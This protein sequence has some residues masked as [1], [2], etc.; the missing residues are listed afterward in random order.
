MSQTT[1]VNTNTQLYTNSDTSKT[2]IGNNRYATGTFNNP[3]YDD[4]D[5]AEG[6]VLGRAHATGYV[7][8]CKSD[9][10]DGS[11][12][13]IGVL[14][15]NVTAPEGDDLELTYCIGGDVA[16]E[17]LVFAKSGDDLD[18][19]VSARNFR[20]R[21]AGDTLGIKLVVGDAQTAY[22]NS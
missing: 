9:A 19:V 7:K 16:E 10:S 8:E 2:F 11:Q 3:T 6:T 1:S 12:Y 18:T 17:K 5:L 4:I 21:I 13:P 15:G 22:D 14:K 20:D